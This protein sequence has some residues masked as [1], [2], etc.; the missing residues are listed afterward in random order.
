MALSINRNEL[1][2]FC[3]RLFRTL[4]GLGL[5]PRQ[6]GWKRDASGRPQRIAPTE[7]E[8]YPRLLFGSIQRYNDVEAG[9]KEWESRILREIE[10]PSVREGYYPELQALF[11][12]M[13]QYKEVF[14]KKPNLQHLRA[15]LYAR[16]F[17]YLYPR[18]V[19]VNAYCVKHQGN[20]EAIDA[21]FIEKALPDSIREE[22]KKLEEVYS[23]EW[24]TIVA[25][26]KA[27][28]I[29]NAAYYRKI[30]R[31]EEF[32]APSEEAMALESQEEI[33]ISKEG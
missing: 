31:G 28:L 32:V 3:P 33:E 17:Q 26:A 19:L 18:R 1:D 11:H 6:L 13:V 20:A 10:S 14:N 30:L 12:W 9:F 16:V 22:V 8:K 29:S 7:F 5:L 2:E 15:S 21:E 23:E 25:D 4:D 24:D 27:S